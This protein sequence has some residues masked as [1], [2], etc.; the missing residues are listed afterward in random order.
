MSTEYAVYHDHL[1]GRI[2]VREVESDTAAA[3]FYDIVRA[4]EYA[5]YL[6]GNPHRGVLSRYAFEVETLS[7]LAGR[8]RDDIEAGYRAAHRDGLDERAVRAW[9]WYR[10]ADVIAHQLTEMTGEVSA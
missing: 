3:E 1:T 5:D 2:T 4:Q 7:I 10:Q 8:L 6:N 9:T